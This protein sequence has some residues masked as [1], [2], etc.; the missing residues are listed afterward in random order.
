MNAVLPLI[1]VAILAGGCTTAHRGMMADERAIV[2]SAASTVAAG[3][4]PTG[5]RASPAQSHRRDSG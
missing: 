1:V 2:S 5:S 4:V 3:R